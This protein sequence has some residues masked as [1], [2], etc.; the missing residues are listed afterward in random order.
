METDSKSRLNSLDE[1]RTERNIVRIVSCGVN[2]QMRQR[3]NWRNPVVPWQDCSNRDEYFRTATGPVEFYL[4]F[5]VTVLARALLYRR[6]NNRSRQERLKA[7]QPDSMSFSG[8]DFENIKPTHDGSPDCG[9]RFSKVRKP[10]SIRLLERTHVCGEWKG[11]SAG[12]K[13]GASLPRGH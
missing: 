7:I 3:G 13:D 4:A 2:P 6:K 5:I 12:Q 8:P 11:T 9:I 10:L 1:L